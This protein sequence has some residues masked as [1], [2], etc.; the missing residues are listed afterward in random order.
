MGF[1]ILGRSA[2]L[3]RLDPGENPQY[4]ERVAETVV[5]LV[6]NRLPRRFGLDPRTDIQ[7]LCP[8]HRGPAGAV[9]LNEKLQATLT[10]EKPHVAERRF[11]GRVYRVGDKVTQMRN[12]YD[13]NVFNG[14]IGVVTRISLEDQQIAVRLDEGDEVLYDFDE[15][16]ELAHA[17][18][19]SIHRSQ[20]SEYPCAVVIVTMSAWQLLQRNLLYTAVTRAKRLVVLVGSTKAIGKAVK[21]NPAGR[22]YAALERLSRRQT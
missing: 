13:K 4:N 8:T 21:T 5:D 22:R 11:G 2:I 9:A 20:G 18:A 12:N 17:Y 7:V 3:E 15:L 10:P 14:S 16:D 6:A 19:V 1:P